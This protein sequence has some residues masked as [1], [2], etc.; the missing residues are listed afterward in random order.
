M[1]SIK[2]IRF[3]LPINSKNVFGEEFKM[4][5]YMDEKQQVIKC[6]EQFNTKQ[7]KPSEVLFN[8]Y[9]AEMNAIVRLVKTCKKESVTQRREVLIDFLATYIGC[10]KTELPEFVTEIID[11]YLL[12][13]DQ[14]PK[15]GSAKQKKL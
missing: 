3:D 7:E 2:R 12:L 10:K 1:K 5:N 8:V 13:T 6:L 11:K 9:P 15:A 4:N 14:N